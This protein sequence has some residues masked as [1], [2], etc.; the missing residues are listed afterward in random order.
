[1]TIVIKIEE[2]K[3]A[4]LLYLI[5]GLSSIIL[6]LITLIWG[7]EGIIDDTPAGIKFVSLGMFIVGLTEIV[8]PAYGSKWAWNTYTTN[9]GERKVLDTIGITLIANLFGI[10]LLFLGIILMLAS[11]F[12]GTYTGGDGGSSSEGDIENF[13]NF[14]I[15][16]EVLLPTTLLPSYMLYLR[17]YWEKHTDWPSVNYIVP[18]SPPQYPPLSPPQ[19]DPEPQNKMKPI[20]IKKKKIKREV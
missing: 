13:L 1:M 11:A 10:V 16:F 18:R 9:T 12:S 15:L 7:I 20:P 2:S 5:G 17:S 19:S 8:L 4:F 3:V 14:M 6:G